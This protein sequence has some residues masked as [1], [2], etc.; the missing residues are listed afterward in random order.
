MKRNN[1][2]K[3]ETGWARRYS[4]R[5]SYRLNKSVKTLTRLNGRCI[6][7]ALPTVGVTR[8]SRKLTH[9]LT[10]IGGKNIFTIQIKQNI[11]FILSCSSRCI[12]YYSNSRNLPRLNI[13]EIDTKV[14]N[15]RKN[16]A[17]NYRKNR[18]V[19]PPKN[20]ETNENENKKL[21]YV[22]GKYISKLETLMKNFQIP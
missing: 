11:T 21:H 3:K 18:N 17:A 14:Q 10:V 13:T 16:I 6:L 1:E 8:F 20:D 4:F 15:L 2:E 12:H 19:V 9:I 22:L 5:Q 7:P